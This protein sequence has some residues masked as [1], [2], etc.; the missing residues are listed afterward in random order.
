MYSSHEQNHVF[1]SSGI[2]IWE[3]QFIGVGIMLIN[4]VVSL[5]PGRVHAKVL[6]KATLCNKAC[7]CLKALPDIF[8][9]LWRFRPATEAVVDVVCLS[10]VVIVVVFGFT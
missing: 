1:L 10:N 5:L 9:C 7:V 3:F 2:Y 8:K 4:L 6:T